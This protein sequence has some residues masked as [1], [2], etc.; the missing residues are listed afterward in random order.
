LRPVG[1]LS[2]ANDGTG[3]Q[4][5]VRFALKT[6]L[7][8]GQ[9]RE[10]EEAD[11]IWIPSTKLNRP[12]SA[13]QSLS[14]SDSH[15]PSPDDSDTRTISGGLR[16]RRRK[17]R[18]NGV[19]SSVGRSRS[20]WNSSHGSE[21]LCM[22]FHLIQTERLHGGI[23]SLVVTCHRPSCG[24]RN[25]RLTDSS[26]EPGLLV[27]GGINEPPVDTSL[28][29]VVV[30]IDVIPEIM[31]RVQSCL[32]EM[33][34]MIRITSIERSKGET[35]GVLDVNLRHG[36]DVELAIGAITKTKLSTTGVENAVGTVTN[37]K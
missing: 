20:R 9:R 11:L 37:E 29:G 23:S 2:D 18:G 19:P 6:S 30:V 4:Q 35:R 1:C 3:G 25:S 28:A 27:R 32:R 24:A 22:S 13:H 36:V 31:L 21:L 5:L 34:G 15:L 16:R 12:S 10:E 26:R 33:F 8:E 14:K 17:G 7:E